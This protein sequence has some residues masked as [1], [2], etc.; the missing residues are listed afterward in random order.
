MRRCKEHRCHSRVSPLRLLY[1][2]PGAEKERKSR[3]G[4]ARKDGWVVVFPVPFHHG[5]SE[6]LKGWVNW[7]GK[8]WALGCR[9]GR[10]PQHRPGGCLEEGLR[11]RNDWKEQKFSAAAAEM[12]FVQS[13]ITRG[14]TEAGWAISSIPLTAVSISVREREI[15]E[16]DFT[17]LRAIKMII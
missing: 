13:K 11:S 9:R 15:I 12:D 8:R 7:D 14:L 4:F 17:K 2:R 6:G 1:G 16:M 5:I 3:G 10:W